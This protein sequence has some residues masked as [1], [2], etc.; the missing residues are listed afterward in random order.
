ML[1]GQGSLQNA[2]LFK[3]K[4]VVAQEIRPAV[5]VVARVGKQRMELKRAPT[6]T[7]ERVVGRWLRAMQPSALRWD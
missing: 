7:G 3:P 4:K 1:G 2:H 6:P 5:R